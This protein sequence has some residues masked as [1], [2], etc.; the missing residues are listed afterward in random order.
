MSINQA[1]PNPTPGPAAID[2]YTQHPSCRDSFLQHRRVGLPSFE[3]AV[4]QKQIFLQ[5]LY[6]IRCERPAAALRALVPD[7]SSWSHFKKMKAFPAHGAD[8]SQWE[9]DNAVIKKS[10][11][12]TYR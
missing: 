4:S 1:R 8:P 2:D 10:Y 5:T 7:D 12:S 11:C 9:G 3:L 6:M